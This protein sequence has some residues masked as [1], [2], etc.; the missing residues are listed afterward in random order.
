MEGYGLRQGD[1]AL[2]IKV[3]NC[4]YE[5]VIEVKKV[6][7]RQLLVNGIPV[8][9]TCNIPYNCSYKITY[10]VEDFY[11]DTKPFEVDDS[12]LFPIEFASMLADKINNEK[13]DFRFFNTII[14]TSFKEK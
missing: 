10:I 3:H 4:Q 14:K 12:N 5:R 13:D 7:I 2:L 11:R 9:K 6:I 1:Y 8:T